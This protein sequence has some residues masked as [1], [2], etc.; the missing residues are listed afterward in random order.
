MPTLPWKKASMTKLVLSL[1]TTGSTTPALTASTIHCSWA[2]A[3]G[4]LKVKP[5]WSAFQ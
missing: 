1:K 2:C 3:S 4:V 5:V